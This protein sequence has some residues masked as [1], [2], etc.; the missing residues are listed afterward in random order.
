MGKFK[1]GDKVEWIDNGFHKGTV[2]LV[3]Y[4]RIVVDGKYV[5]DALDLY[6]E[7]KHPFKNS[8]A[9]SN[10]VVQNALEV[11]NARDASGE[12]ISRGDTVIYEDEE[13]DDNPTEY[14]V[15]GVEGD[16]VYLSNG[17][18]A[19]CRDLLV[20]N[21]CASSNPVANAS[22]D[23]ALQEADAGKWDSVTFFPRVITGAGFP[24]KFHLDGGYDCED[25]V[26]AA[27]KSG[28][29]HL[30]I[31]YKNG[32]K[33]KEVQ[34][35]ATAPRSSNPVVNAAVSYA[36]VSGMLKLADGCVDDGDLAEAEEILRETKSA[37]SRTGLASE[38]KRIAAKAGVK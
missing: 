16:Y 17:N 4:N 8:C 34:I 11:C 27:A 5:V 33:K 21:S 10:A 19:Y 23:S 22:I 12:P 26:R 24:D 2:T 6:P 7:G 38:W 20:F 9:T 37:A 25:L 28:K 29:Y 13:D 15:K 3:D 30:A 14:R 32:T 36:D 18:H 35:N 1:V 31:F